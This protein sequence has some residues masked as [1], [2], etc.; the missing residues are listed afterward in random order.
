MFLE[1]NN[2]K[3][4]KK[5]EGIIPLPSSGGHVASGFCSLLSSGGNL[6]ASLHSP[7]LESGVSI[8]PGTE[9]RTPTHRDLYPG[10]TAYCLSNSLSVS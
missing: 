5:Q 6:A 2:L 1:M 8:R 10:Q 9:D 7:F 4:G 3:D